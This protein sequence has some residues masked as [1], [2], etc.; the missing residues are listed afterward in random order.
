MSRHANLKH[1]VNEAY[2]GEEGYYD[3]YGGEGGIYQDEYGNY[4]DYGDEYGEEAQ[5]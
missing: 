2:Q 5:V 1:I 3:E 4:G